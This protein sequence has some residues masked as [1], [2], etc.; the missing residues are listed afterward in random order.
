MSFF[1]RGKLMKKLIIFLT[2]SVFFTNCSSPIAHNSITPHNSKV[3][4]DALVYKNED[5]FRT[6]ASVADKDFPV[7]NQKSEEEF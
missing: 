4:N 3:M 7:I 2:L 1:L 6:I 5:R